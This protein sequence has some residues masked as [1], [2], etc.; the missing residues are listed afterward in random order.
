MKELTE[1]QDVV[2]RFIQNCI[3]FVGT[4]PTYKEIG[5]A[6]GIS[7]TSAVRQKIMA[8][9]KKGYIQKPNVAY[10]HRNLVL[11]R[12][13]EIDHMKDQCVR[14]LNTET[15]RLTQLKAPQS[16]WSVYTVLASCDP[17]INGY[18]WP[19]IGSIEDKLGGMLS[20][21]RIYSALAWLAEHNMIKKNKWR[22]NGKINKKRFILTLRNNY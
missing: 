22:V 17:K 18:C 4:P 3:W 6:C 11:I 2:L 12:K 5:S 15:L 19:S 13:H 8:L 14:M 9:I 1:K 10:T 21:R 7:E 20:E 16:V